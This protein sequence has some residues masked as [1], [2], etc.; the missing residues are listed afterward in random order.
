MQYARVSVSALPD[1]DF[2]ELNESLY[3]RL[4]WVFSRTQFSNHTVH[5]MMLHNQL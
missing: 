4:Q 5:Y 1:E 2:A 3:N